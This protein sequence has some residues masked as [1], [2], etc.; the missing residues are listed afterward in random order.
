MSP[1]TRRSSGS[2]TAPVGLQGL[3]RITALVLELVALPIMRAVTLKPSFSWAWT[4]ILRRRDVP[5]PGDVETGSADAALPRESS[6]TPCRQ[7]RHLPG[8]GQEALDL[9][10]SGL[11]RTRRRAD[12]DVGCAGPRDR[13]RVCGSQSSE[14]RL[15]RRPAGGHL[16]GAQAQSDSRAKRRIHGPAGMAGEDGGP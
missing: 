6:G 12:I 2:I 14:A 4:R 7:A 15:P 10:T 13:G 5:S 3:C 16:Q 8:A 1:M 9:E 11:F